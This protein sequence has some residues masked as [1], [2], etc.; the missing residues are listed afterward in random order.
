MVRMIR[1]QRFGASFI[2]L[3]LAGLAMPAHALTLR[4]ALEAAYL[5]APAL[6]AERAALEAIDEQYAQ[7]R[8][9]YFPQLSA[10]G[11]LTVRDAL[12][13]RDG[14]ASDGE[15]SASAA[16]AVSVQQIVYAGGRLDAQARLSLAE[17]GAAYA[18]YDGVRQGFLLQTIDAYLAVLRDGE[19]ER[20]SRNN[21]SVL[22]R[23]REAAA[24]RF[25][26]G[27]TTRT[28]VS[29]A[30][31]R[32]S[33]ARA[34]LAQAQAGLSA[35][36]A[37]FEALTGLP[38]TGLEAA[39]LPDAGQVALEP[40]LEALLNVHPLLRAAAFRAE[41]AEA[42]RV[43]AKAA[44]R[45]TVSLGS[46]ASASRGL[47]SGGVDQD[48]ISAGASVSVP[49]FTGGLNASRVRAAE[50]RV[51]EARLALRA[52]ER[53]RREAVLTSFAVLQAARDQL[54]AQ[55]S[56]VGAA[57]L[58]F[59]GV[60]EEARVGFRTTLD[61]LNAQ[62]E[63]LDAELA[64]VT[65]ERDLSLAYYRF[66]QACGVLTPLALSLTDVDATPPQAKPSLLSDLPNPIARWSN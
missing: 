14:F 16:V 49:L 59:E 63:L 10:S 44:H 33:A 18:A 6:Q 42:G 5:N 25:E 66:L 17:I 37:R 39:F 55:K 38:A 11:D 52:E 12:L 47:L 56:G 13:A 50:A 24:D 65:S 61:V 41:A 36:R 20:I 45:P 40:A 23:Q 58:A 46:T 48:A 54:A 19:V 31:A 28:D 34:G 22:E 30:E 27:E 57:R 32:L 60:E 64:E 53:V 35:S 21:L 8:A 3:A 9:A 43:L 62:Q 4:E 1:F 29:Q 2:A 51:N 15:T 7:A 26:V